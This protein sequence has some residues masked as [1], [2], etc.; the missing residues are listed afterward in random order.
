[1]TDK[2]KNPAIDLSIFAARLVRWLR[3]AD[4]AP[5][6]SGAEA[7]AMAVI[8]HSGG[9]SP[10]ALAQLEQVRRPTIT[11][12]VDGLVLR[13]L[14]RRDRHP[15]DLRGSIIVATDAGRSVWDAGQVR[16]VAPLIARVNALS[17]QERSQLE[18]LM[19]LLDGLTRPPRAEE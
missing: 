12:L 4:A 15:Q 16:R 11:K 9:I 1:M 10:S 5:Q 18:D 6:L 13:G 14:V 7:S 19:P 3:A 17:L 2:S 8:V